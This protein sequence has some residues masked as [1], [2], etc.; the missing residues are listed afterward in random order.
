MRIGIDA[1]NFVSGLTGIGRYVLEM[2]RHLTIQGHELVLYLP[3]RPFFSLPE[4]PG[5]SVRISKHA[6]GVR[7]LIWGQI[8]LPRLAAADGLDIF[9]GPAHRLPV[10]LSRRIPCVVTI[11]DLVWKNAAETMRLQTWLGERALMKPAIYGADRVVAVSF[12]TAGA[13]RLTFPVATGK[14]SV[15]HSGLTA[16]SNDFTPESF[17]AFASRHRID[18]PYA[19]FVGTLEPRKNLF[20]L[21]EAYSRLSLEMRENFFLV[22]AGGQ[23]WHLGN[24]T[25][26]IAQLGIEYSVRLTGYVTDG[27]L[28]GLYAN[29]RFLVMPSLYEGFG[30]PIIEANA[31]GIPVLTSNTS[32]MPEVAGDAALLVDPQNVDALTCAMRRLASDEHLLRHL[33]ARSRLNAARFDWHKSAAEMIKIFEDVITMRNKLR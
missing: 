12:A 30:F 26:L 8:V 17:T 21:L 9:W 5:A 18:R 29:A 1:R 22:I 25:T 33:A 19:L 2:C 16:L 10:F 6:G 11:H 13:V 14:L 15:V 28:A 27:E 23:G 31:M 7:R 20:R 24:L 32:S 3:E 4:W